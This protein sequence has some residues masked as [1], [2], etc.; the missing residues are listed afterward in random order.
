MPC[1]K[2]YPLRLQALSAARSG[3][4]TGLQERIIRACRGKA[5]H[6]DCAATLNF[7]KPSGA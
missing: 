6:V 4:A 1:E 7:H 5:T 2:T 3:E